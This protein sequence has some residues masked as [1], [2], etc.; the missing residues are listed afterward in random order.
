MA[1]LE[2]TC[3]NT[4]DCDGLRALSTWRERLGGWVERSIEKGVNERG[5]TQAGLALKR[6]S[7]IDDG[8]G[9]RHDNDA[10]QQP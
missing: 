3:A 4:L 6:G 1:R 2:R 5:F 10:Y 8:A 7:S 9:E